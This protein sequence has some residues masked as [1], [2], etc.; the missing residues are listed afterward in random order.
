MYIHFNLPCDEQTQIRL[1]K[2][3]RHRI[4][5]WK[6]QGV[7]TRA[8]LTYHFIPFI[9]SNSLYV[10][11]DIPAVDETTKSEIELSQEELKQIPITIMR[12]I[13]EICHDSDIKPSIINYRLEIE[14]DKKKKEQR[15]EVYYD[16]AP[17]KEIIHFASVGTKV[18][19]EVLKRLEENKRIWKSDKELAR[20]ILLRLKDEVGADYKWLDWILH[21]VCNPL[22]IHENQILQ[23]NGN[24]AIRSIG[25]RLRDE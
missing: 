22:L 14:Q 3:F 11:L 25:R 20:F 5:E 17:V 9:P 19:F 12:S 23:P 24:L 2:I 10:C 13:N 6:K 21:F 18:A 7:V 16:G 4:E 15:R 8:V 1:H